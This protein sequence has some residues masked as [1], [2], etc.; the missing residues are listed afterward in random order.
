MHKN[1]GLIINQLDS[2]KSI[3]QQK[4]KFTNKRIEE[5][6]PEELLE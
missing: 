2:V 5:I 3:S 4:K 6:E 1:H